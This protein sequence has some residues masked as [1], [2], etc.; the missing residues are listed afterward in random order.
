MS[1]DE[2][3]LAIASLWGLVILF[4][5]HRHPD[6]FDLRHLLT[7][8]RSNRVSLRKCGQLFA[9]LLSSWVLIHETRA[10]RL[11]EWLFIGYLAAWTGANLAAKWIDTK[12][13][14]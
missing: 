10:G 9:L 12:K 7:D 8:S 4:L 14:N 3:T 13:E 1:Q 11:S 2:L 5:W 6:A